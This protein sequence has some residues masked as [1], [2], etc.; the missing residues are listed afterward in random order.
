MS[1][2][3]FIR[4][5]WISIRC[6]YTLNH[7]LFK[8]KKALLLCKSKDRLETYCIYLQIYLPKYSPFFKVTKFKK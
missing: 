5:T 1:Q 8:A 2:N 6:F 3:S 4:S 7:V